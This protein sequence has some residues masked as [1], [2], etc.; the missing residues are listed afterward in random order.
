[1][2]TEAGVQKTVAAVGGVSSIKYG[3]PVG[4]AVVDKAL[5]DFGS[6][7]PTEN[8]DIVRNRRITEAGIRCACCPLTKTTRHLTA[9]QEYLRLLG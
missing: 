7:S 5:V 1:M 3:R 8:A 9:D 2:A 6:E 4:M